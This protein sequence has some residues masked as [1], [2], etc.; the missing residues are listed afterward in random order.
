MMAVVI[1]APA[2][3]WRARLE[4]SGPLFTAAY[5]VSERWTTDGGYDT[6]AEWQEKLLESIAPELHSPEDLV[7]AAQF[8]FVEQVNV[9]P[10]AAVWLVGERAGDVLRE[11]AGRLSLLERTTPEA[12]AALF[13]ELR[14]ALK[15]AWGLRGREVM[16]PIR[17]ALTGR[18]EGPCLE[19]VVCL[20][21]RRRCLERLVGAKD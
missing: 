8:A 12:V 14:A 20:L 11:C 7:A 10:A 6:P 18:V 9:T 13:K 4:L 19:I 1:D 21:G 16:M 5:G 3:S 2:D 15:A 17:A